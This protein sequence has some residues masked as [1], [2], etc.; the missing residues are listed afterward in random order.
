M[1]TSAPRVIPQ[2]KL[3][4]SWWASMFPGSQGA[5]GSSLPNNLLFRTLLVPLMAEQRVFTAAQSRYRALP[6]RGVLPPGRPRGHARQRKDPSRAARS[7]HRPRGPDASGTGGQ[8]KR[9][10]K[11]CERCEK[12]INTTTYRQQVSDLATLEQS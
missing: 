8:R 4:R 12:K 6:P 3:H 1:P 11:W 7:P 2:N 10:H 9:R 5:V